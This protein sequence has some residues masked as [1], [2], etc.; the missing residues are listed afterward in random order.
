[1]HIQEFLNFSFFLLEA[2]LIFSCY[3]SWVLLA[4]PYSREPLTILKPCDTIKTL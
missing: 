2:D 3:I 1:M 4:D